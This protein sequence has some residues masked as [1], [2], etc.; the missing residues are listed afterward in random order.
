LTFGRS[1]AQSW[2]PECPNVKNQKQWV[3][4]VWQSVK[5]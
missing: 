1:D 3:R 2:A 4:P 5:P